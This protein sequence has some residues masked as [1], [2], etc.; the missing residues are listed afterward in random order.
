VLGY[1]VTSATR[2]RLLELLWRHDASGSVSELAKRID[3]S[4][5]GTYRELQEM[6]RQGLA[7]TQINGGAEV[8]VAASDHPDADLMRRLVSS[9]PRAA[10]RNRVNNAVIRRRLRGLG[11]PLPDVPEQVD[12][13]QREDVLVA[14]VGLAHADPTIARVLPFAF[15]RTRTEIDLDRLEAAARVAHEKQAVGFFLAL[16]SELGG[17][18]KLARWAER[19]RDG[20]VS[21]PRHFFQL[22]STR[23]GDRTAARRT[24]ALARQWGFLMDL[25]LDAFR[26]QFEKFGRDEAV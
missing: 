11:A 8:Y 4:Y 13:E 15:W 25:E 24:P 12:P 2:R 17:D 6:V 1:L 22:P 23:E 7:T 20:R 26:S 14:G 5:A 18:R 9:S 19:M 21:R 10:D 16:T 3:L